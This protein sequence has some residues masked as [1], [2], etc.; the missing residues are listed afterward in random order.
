M[1][2]AVTVADL[3]PELLALRHEFLAEV[4]EDDGDLGGRFAHRGDEVAVDT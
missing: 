2:R 3:A 4:A 1:M